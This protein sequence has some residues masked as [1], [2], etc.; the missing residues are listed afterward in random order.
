MRLL[1][2]SEHAE[3]VGQHTEA[4]EPGE[5]A[6]AVEEEPG[7]GDPELQG[8]GAEAAQ[9]HLPAGEGAGPLHQR[10]VRPHAE[11]WSQLFVFCIRIRAGS[12]S[13]GFSFL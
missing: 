8:G 3:G 10:G 5:A 1:H 13:S 7:A 9:D 6:R 12:S 11:G 2:V 4:A